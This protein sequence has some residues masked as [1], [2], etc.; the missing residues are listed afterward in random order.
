M[1]S[2]R[3]SPRVELKPT[4]NTRATTAASV[5]DQRKRNRPPKSDEA[6]HSPATISIARTQT[7]PEPETWLGSI[8]LGQ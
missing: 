7:R 3:S 6:I 8:S 1:A 5:H 2:R 4:R